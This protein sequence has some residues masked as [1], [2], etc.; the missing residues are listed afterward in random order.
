MK[1]KTNIQHTA[2]RIL[3]QLLMALVKSS[4]VTCSSVRCKPSIA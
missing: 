2:E 3:V 1:M 4:N